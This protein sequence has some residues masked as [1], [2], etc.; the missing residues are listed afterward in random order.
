MFRSGRSP[1]P[2]ILNV[3]RSDGD[4]RYAIGFIISEL[5]PGTW[6]VPRTGGSRD[7]PHFTSFAGAGR[8]TTD[9][10]G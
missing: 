1:P 6:Q 5:L 3:D 8:H 2:P 10:V 7:M 9:P 4:V